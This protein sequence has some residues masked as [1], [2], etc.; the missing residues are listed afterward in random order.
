MFEYLS[1]FYKILDYDENN[2]LKPKS[3]TN[4]DTNSWLQLQ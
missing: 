3:K 2:V 4:I 1:I